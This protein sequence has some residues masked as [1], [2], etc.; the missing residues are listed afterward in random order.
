MGSSLPADLGRTLTGRLRHC[1]VPVSR[2]PDGRRLRLATDFHPPEGPLSSFLAATA[3]VPPTALPPSEVPAA[4]REWVAASPLPTLL[5]T[6]DGVTLVA[7]DAFTALLARVNLGP[8]AFL[9]GP[10]RDNLPPDA[11]AQEFFRAL[12]PGDCVVRQLTVPDHRPYTFHLLK[13]ALSAGSCLCCVLFP[14]ADP[15]DVRLGNILNAIA[16]FVAEIDGQGNLFFLN[17]RLAEHLGYAPRPEGR[18]SHLR[19]FW[20]GF[21]A[22]RLAHLLREVDARGLAHF[23]TEFGRRDGTVLAMEVSLVASQT[24]GDSLYLLTARDL[25]AQLTHER[26]LQD[27]LV[28]SQRTVGAVTAENHR[29]R[30]REDQATATGQLVYASEAFTG[31]MGQVHRVAPTTATVLIT[32]ETGTGKELIARSI[33]RLSRR[34]GRPFVTV[35][36]GSLP[37]DLIESELFGYRKGA[38]T[39]ATRDH[40]GR[41][42]AAD[43]GTIFLDEIGELPLPQQSRLLRVLQEGQYMPLGETRLHTVDVRVIA[44]TNRDLG[45]WVAEGKF[46]SDLF[47]RLN[48]FPIH[49]IPLRERREDIA[50]L[51]RHFIQK[52]NPKFSKEITGVDGTTLQRLLEY[53]FPGNVRELENMVERAFII[54]SGKLLPIA[55]PETAPRAPEQPVLDLFDGTLTEFLSFEDYQRRYIQ[56][57]L[58]STNGRVSGAGG[59]R[60]S[61]RFIRKRCSARC[62]NWGFGADAPG[63]MIG[64]VR[65]QQGQLY[66]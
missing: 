3:L 11:P 37:P 1:S 4:V 48:V 47:F 13:L 64:V 32:G 28:E 39:G 31:V 30:A 58:E 50:P 62:G 10:L 19:Q 2:P 7:N 61:Y 25:T 63:G 55:L 41:F 54:A 42:A 35:D 51:I 17:D 65:H 36:C 33:H 60:R 66:R 20:P 27:A 23:R 9:R 14:S 34:A 24:P 57:V 52:F 6:E 49:S 56:L 59:R 8:E 26:S 15:A 5:F 22:D 45:R 38:F 18:P 16:C 43:G 46:R 44:A 21:R 29:L 53:P 40:P 12:R